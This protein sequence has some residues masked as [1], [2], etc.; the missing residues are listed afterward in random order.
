VSNFTSSKSI[1]DLLGVYR[2]R[3]SLDAEVEALVYSLAG[4]LVKWKDD[5]L[6]AHL[7]ARCDRCEQIVE[8]EKVRVVE[9]ISKFVSL[10]P[11]DPFS[12]LEIILKQDIFEVVCKECMGEAK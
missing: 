6:R 8:I 10:S 7:Y 5:V 12:K 3:L 9:D 4:E 11:P 2:E 1:V